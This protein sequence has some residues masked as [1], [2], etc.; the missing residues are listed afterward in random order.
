[1]PLGF[2]RLKLETSSGV[3]EDCR[4]NYRAILIG[5]EFNLKDADKF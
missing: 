3:T 5:G 4:F 2:R 1:M